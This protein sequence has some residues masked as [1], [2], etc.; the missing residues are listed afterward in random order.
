LTITR[1]TA[2]KTFLEKLTLSDDG[3][4]FVGRNDLGLVVT[5]TRAET[6]RQK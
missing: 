5:G 2:A 4:Y 6:T 1:S 3:S